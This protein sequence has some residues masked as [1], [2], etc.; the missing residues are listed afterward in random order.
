[1]ATARFFSE[2]TSMGGVDYAI[3]IDD[4]LG[5]GSP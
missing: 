5:I 2:F 3:T 1:M 4:A